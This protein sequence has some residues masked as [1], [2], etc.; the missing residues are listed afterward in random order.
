MLKGYDGIKR[1]LI[2]IKEKGFG[3]SAKESAVGDTL[4]VALEMLARGF[5]FKNIDITKI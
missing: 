1:R 4:A 3:A 5:T 2:E